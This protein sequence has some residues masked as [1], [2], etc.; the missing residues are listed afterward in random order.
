MDDTCGERRQQNAGGTHG[1]EGSYERWAALDDYEF[2]RAIASMAD[3][4]C[5]GLVWSEER[6]GDEGRL[7]GGAWESSCRDNFDGRD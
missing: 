1:D 3:A 6:H 2:E 5:D 7:E 4:C